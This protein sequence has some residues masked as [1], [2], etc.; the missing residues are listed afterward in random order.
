[1]TCRDERHQH[2]VVILSDTSVLGIVRIEQDASS[3]D[4]G[5]ALLVPACYYTRRLGPPNSIHRVDDSLFQGAILCTS[6]Q[7]GQGQP[8]VE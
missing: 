1:M 3:G 4:T 7:V 2:G 5:G 6:H 8:T